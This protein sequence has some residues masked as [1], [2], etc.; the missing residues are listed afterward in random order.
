MDPESGDED[1]RDLKIA[2]E[3]HTINPEVTSPPSEE[4]QSETERIVTEAVEAGS[5]SAEVEAK[6]TGDGAIVP[7]PS[8][9]KPSPVDEAEDRDLEMRQP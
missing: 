6:P 8:P 3:N 4:D 2:S 1:I 5:S 9:K 7:S